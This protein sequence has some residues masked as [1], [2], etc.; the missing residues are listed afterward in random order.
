VHQGQR[1]KEEH[2]LA[3]RGLIEMGGRSTRDVIEGANAREDVP[4][5][6]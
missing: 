4:S 5:I 3:L 2:P 6:S 1:L